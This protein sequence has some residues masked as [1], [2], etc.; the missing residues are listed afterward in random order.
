MITKVTKENKA[1][2]NA[3]FEKA[4]NDSQNDAITS[5]DAYFAVITQ[6]AN[7]DPIFTVLPL[8][9][10]TFDINANSRAIKVP[11]EYKKNGISVQGDEIAEIIYFSVDRYF[12]SVDLYDEDIRIAI[13]W[14]GASHDRVNG[15][16]GVSSEHIR[17]ITTR[18]A[19]DKMIFGWALNSDITKYPGTIKFAVR[20]YKLQTG[21]DGQP[22][23]TFSLSTLTQSATINPAL[24]F[25]IKQG[26]FDAKVYNDSAKIKNRLKNSVTPSEL[27]IALP[28]Y[29][30]LN[31]PTEGELDDIWGTV[32]NPE[33]EEKPYALI[34]L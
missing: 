21:D 34:D 20:F 4:R 12:D 32:A 8:D 2:Y 1:L 17:D 22:E 14:E 15:L 33:N 18:K 5:L 11:E 3:W 7:I 26:N 16:Q 28:P 23:I 31:L 10:P 24:D 30:L 13:Q 6:L 9:K 27:D 19:E 29:F 25:T